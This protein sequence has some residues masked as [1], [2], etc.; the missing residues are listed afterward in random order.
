MIAACEQ[1]GTCNVVPL[2]QYPVLLADYLQHIST[3]LKFVLY[4]EAKSWR[5]YDF[6][7]HDISVIIGPEGGFS[8]DEIRLLF[9]HQFMPLSLGAR[10]FCAQK[11]PQL[12]VLSVLQA[13]G[14]DL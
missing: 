8:E 6:V 4:P 10:E 2:V 12:V 1:S 7:A 14:G 13:V 5:D 3:S 11:L 9:A